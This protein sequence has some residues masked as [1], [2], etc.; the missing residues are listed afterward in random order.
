MSQIIEYRHIYPA[1]LDPIGFSFDNTIYPGDKVLIFVSGG[2]PNLGVAAISIR[3]SFGTT[4]NQ[5]FNAERPIAGFPLVTT[6]YADI[7]TLGSLTVYVSSDANWDI[8]FTAIVLRGYTLG[9]PNAFNVVSTI[10]STTPNVI[11]LTTTQQTSIFTYWSNENDLHPVPTWFAPLTQLTFD[12]GH[13][14]STA[15]QLCVPAGTTNYGYTIDGDAS[16]SILAAVAFQEKV[17]SGLPEDFTGWQ[18]YAGPD[19]VTPIGILSNA[20]SGCKSR[21]LNDTN[22]IDWVAA[23]GTPLAMAILPP[24]VTSTT[25]SSIEDGFDNRTDSTLSFNDSTRTFTISPVLAGFTVWTNKKMWTITT[26]QSIQL[27]D[28]DGIWFIYYNATGALAAT[29]TFTP[30]LIT[31]NAIVCYVYWNVATQTHS[32]F[33]EERHGR[34][35]ANTVHVYLHT[36]VGTKYSSGLSPSGLVSGD[37]SSNTHAQVGYTDGIIWDEDIQIDITNGAPQTIASIAQI[38]LFYRS[39]TGAVWTKIPA[40]SFPVTNTGSGRAAFN[41]FNAGSWKLT[42]CG[43]G[44]YVLTHIYATNDIENP[45]I[46]IIGQKTYNTTKKANKGSITEIQSIDLNGIRELT[47]E[48]ITLSTITFQTSSSYNNIVKSRAIP[49]PDGG[50]CVDWRIN[51]VAAISASVS[52]GTVSSPVQSFNTRVGDIVLGSSDVT[53]ALTYT[54]YDASN[55]AGYITAA[56]APV[57]SFNTRTG[58]IALSS[59]DVT[60]AL[61]YTPYN[62]TN[63]ANYTT[64]AAV[65]GVGYLTSAVSTF[66]TRT[67]AVTLSSSD[68]TTAL[69][70]TPYNATNPSGYIT[71]AGTATNFSGSLVGDVAGTQGATVVGK[72]NGTS[73]AGL[74][75]GI[76]KN[77]TSTGVPSIAIAAD[78]PILNQNTTGTATNATNVLSTSTTAG[79]AYPILLSAITT[80]GQGSPLFDA[81]LT[82][83][84]STDALVLPS[85]GSVSAG[86]L[87][88]TVATGTPPFTVAST[89]QVANL[90][91]STAGTVI[92][93]AQPAIT[94]VGTLTGLTVT[95]PIVG[96]ITGNAA[97]ANGLTSATTTISISGAAAPTAGQALVAISPTSAGWSTVSGGAGTTVNSIQVNLGSNPTSGGSF[98]ISGSGF[99]V[100]KSVVITQSCGP[101]TGKG[102]IPD[103]VSMDQLTVSAYVVN[104]TTINAYWGSGSKVVGYYEFDYWQSA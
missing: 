30:A 45:I 4:Y 22:V 77:T 58:A 8:G 84:P 18:Y 100:G 1:S 59:N 57:Q 98:T 47:P 29:Q 10:P 39:G 20:A 69:T 102:S 34:E 87:I 19:G 38:P 33:G 67:G 53:T 2:M 54:P 73:L 7:T 96:S 90:N 99:V 97:T 104:S 68:V 86:T 91:A 27:P 94:S 43:E 3:D 85:I 40:T 65:A 48:W 62:A 93:A 82:Y 31:T 83:N 49:A 56:G 25:I 76:L 78:F 41:D 16:N 21:S 9:A 46:G 13:Y 95:A 12:A 50:I 63:P 26:P 28:T 35:M 72:V 92:T 103:E 89:T 61:T 6:F 71:A 60:T 55:P 101:Y 44:D 42:E 15:Y 23:G 24:Q 52:A 75:T 36:T 80:T 51:T 37:G 5:I 14:D 81:D 70:F 79:S 64:L 66:N 32:M 11:P 17:V 88:S 74:A